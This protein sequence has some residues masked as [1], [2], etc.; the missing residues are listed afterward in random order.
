MTIIALVA[1]FGGSVVGCVN[2]TE[3]NPVHVTAALTFFV[4]YD[5]FMVMAAY[6]L[7]DKDFPK[8]IVAWVASLLS[9]ATKVRFFSG[10]AGL[11]S[12]VDPVPYLEWSDAAAIIPFLVTYM[13]A[14][15]D[16]K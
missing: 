9:I 1:F 16:R 5:I 3:N 10:A 7:Y 13:A 2:E 8:S 11:V 15:G 6:Q 4:G 12:I 14:F